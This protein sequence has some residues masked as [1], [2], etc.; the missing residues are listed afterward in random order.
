MLLTVDIL[1]TVN[2]IF[3]WK[4][5]LN[6]LGFFLRAISVWIVSLP[7]T[8]SPLLPLSRPS[9][10]LLLYYLASLSSTLKR[11]STAH[12]P[13]EQEQSSQ[14]LKAQMHCASVCS[15]VQSTKCFPYLKDTE[16]TQ[17]DICCLIL[18]T[19]EGGSSLIHLSRTWESDHYNALEG[20]VNWKKVDVKISC[21]SAVYT[22]LFYSVH[23]YKGGFLTCHVQKTN[24]TVG[25]LECS[26]TW[27]WCSNIF[28]KLS[29]LRLFK[30]LTGYEAFEGK[31]AAQYL[32][33]LYCTI[34]SGMEAWGNVIQLKSAL[35]AY[36]G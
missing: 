13:W 4:K 21:L 16:E 26:Q 9:S 10:S 36:C 31:E 27:S 3:L 2:S 23:E 18:V 34:V 7:V 15:P 28:H 14:Q 19:E 32:T 17:T 11:R 29:L 24:M 20:V 33:V 22:E 25:L 1:K 30:T 35:S 12:S 8:A 6:I 5:V